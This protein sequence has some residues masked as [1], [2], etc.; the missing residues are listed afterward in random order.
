MFDGVHIGHRALLQELQ[1][2]ANHTVVVTFEPHPRQVLQPQLPHP[3]LLTPLPEKAIRLKK[4][5]ITNIIVIPFTRTFAE[6]TPSDYI[7]YLFYE[8]IHTSHVLIGYDHRFGKNRAGG[9]SELQTIGTQLGFV[10]QSFP[11]YTDN[12]IDQLPVSSTRIRNA[13]MQRQI[14]LAT[15]LLGRYYSLRATVIE[16][17]KLGRTIGYPTAN[18]QP[19]HA[20]QLLPGLGVYAV[21]VKLADSPDQTFDGILNYGLR[22][23]VDTIANAPVIEVH[24]FDFQQDI[25][26]QQIEVFF[27]D[28][29]RLE[30]R[31]DSLSSLTA[32]LDTDSRLA[33]QLLAT[34]EL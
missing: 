25:Y 15:R 17:K 30:K 18:L 3:Q 4:T 11:A 16:G 8:L 20:Q 29:L 5:G 31:F 14:P 27:V 7:Y 2:L 32:Q 23:T 19:I 33:R 6:T 22:P 34:V 10:A 28:C 9:I 24:I 26:G 1:T 21:K 12:H 13:I